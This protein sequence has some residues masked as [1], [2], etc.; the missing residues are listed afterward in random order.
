MK[1][2]KGQQNDRHLDSPSESNQEKHINFREVEEDS[3][4]NIT[5]NN[6]NQTD[7]QKQWERGV[8]EGKEAYSENPR[9]DSAL[10]M[11][12]DETLGIP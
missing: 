6:T 8:E 1:D 10:P 3:S 2:N 11:D 9:S 4:L 5:W 7:R 12:N